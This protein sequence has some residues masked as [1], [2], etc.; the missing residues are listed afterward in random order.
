MG[1]HSCISSSTP[2]NSIPAGASHKLRIW[3]RSVAPLAA[4]NTSAYGLPFND[5]YIYQRIWKEDSFKIGSRLDFE[6]LGA[7]M[8]M[9]FSAGGPET[10]V[11]P[12]AAASLDLSSPRSLFKEKRAGYDF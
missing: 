5:S 11:M 12:T 7:K 6:S 10:I 3:I 9:G 4:A 8:H 2:S 1:S